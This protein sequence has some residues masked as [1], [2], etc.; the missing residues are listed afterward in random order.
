MFAARALLRLQKL[1]VAQVLASRQRPAAMSFAPRGRAV[2]D[3]A[4]S[5]ARPAVTSFSE[6]EE[7]L[8]D[9]VAQFAATTVQPLVKQMDRDSHMPKEIFDGLFA[10][11]L[12]GIEMPPQFGGSGASFTSAILAIEE[13]A[14]VDASV[15]VLVDI[16]NTLIN[17]MFKFWGSPQLLEKWG[18]RLCTDTV[19]SF[20][21]SES[22]SGS[23]AFALKTTADKS[24][25]GG[26]YTING[27]KLWISNAEHAGVFL[28]MANVDVSAG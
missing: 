27:S 4:A 8:R 18:P 11:G 16:H 28:V 22:G 7:M 21:L 24:S 26:H 15:S 13:L 5:A 1:P 6:D 14:K 9:A 2:G 19:G 23:D 3:M 10:N 17:N 12:M 20:C 25:D